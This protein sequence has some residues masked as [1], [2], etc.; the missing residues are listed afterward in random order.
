[1]T[2]YY[3]FLSLEFFLIKGW[4][5]LMEAF[6]PIVLVEKETQIWCFDMYWSN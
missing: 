3:K 6:P 2:D 1:M 5:L 4:D